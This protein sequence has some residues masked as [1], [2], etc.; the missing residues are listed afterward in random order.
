[1]RPEV[2]GGHLV[3]F[4]SLCSSSDAVQEPVYPICDLEGQQV[5]CF[6]GLGTRV[7]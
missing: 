1:M 2:P 3:G 7:V 5:L 6:P 4:A